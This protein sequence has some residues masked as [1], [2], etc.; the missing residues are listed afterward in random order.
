VKKSFVKDLARYAPSQF[1]PALTA[2]VTTPILTRLLAPAEYGYWA[3]ASS[4]AGFLTALAATAVGS[5]V[6]R[7]YP[8]YEANS[9]L[10]VFL[11]TVAGSLILVLAAVTGVSVLVLYVIK[12][13]APAWLLSLLPLVILIFVAQSIFTVFICVIRAQGRS[14]SFSAFQL[15]TSYGGLGLGL[16][17]VGVLKFGVEGLLW[18]TLLA[19]IAVLPFLVIE[20]TRKV[21]IHPREFQVPVASQLWGYAWPLALGDVALWGLRVS[22]LFIIGSFWPARDVGLYTVSYN[23][24]AKSIDLLV[25]LFLLGLGPL[26]YRTWEIQGREATERT[27]TMVTRVYLIVCLPAAVG[28]SILALPFVKLLTAPEYYEGS[29]I[30]G[31][32]V[33]SSFAWGLI[34]IANMGLTIKQQARRLAVNTIIA[35]AIHI[36]LQLLLVPRFGYVASAVSTLIGYAVLL[37]LQTLSSR[38]HLAWKFPFTTLR[39][40]MAASILMGLVAW[41]TYGMVRADSKVAPG[42]L[43]VS[44]AL[45]VTTYGFCLWWLGE[46]DEREKKTVEM[47]W[48][49]VIGR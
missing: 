24:S 25:S 46:V 38:P 20:A 27:L 45:A 13:L 1:L 10:D 2:F 39:N 31:F 22:D 40:V 7:F 49:R 15:L 16:L 42:Y 6:L 26:V 44:I 43:G 19:Q 11:A 5:A 34:N 28:L 37:F 35:A 12:D 30:V 41:G 14:G 17:L 36:T 8:A 29:R 23:I 18:G 48:A 21:G 33:C 3:Q 32:V 4:V 9:T 47:M